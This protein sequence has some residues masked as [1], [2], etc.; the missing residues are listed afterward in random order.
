[1][2]EIYL[3]FICEVKGNV[4]SLTCVHSCYSCSAA[5]LEA[6][7]FYNQLHRKSHY[8]FQVVKYPVL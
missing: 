5:A 7:K 1:M 3:L 2:E 8:V 4:L 6:K